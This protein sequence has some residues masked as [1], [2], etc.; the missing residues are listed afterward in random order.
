MIKYFTLGSGYRGERTGDI[1]KAI[2]NGI[3]KVAGKV[4]NFAGGLITNVADKFIK[5]MLPGK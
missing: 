2:W 4:L 5:G 3:K 1:V